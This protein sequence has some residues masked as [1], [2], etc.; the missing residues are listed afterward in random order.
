MEM[1]VQVM[2]E[3]SS[4]SSLPASEITNLNDLLQGSSSFPTITYICRIPT[5]RLG[6]GTTKEILLSNLLPPAWLGRC[7]SRYPDPAPDCLPNGYSMY[8][9]VLVCHRARGGSVAAPHPVP[10][11]WRPGPGPGRRM[12]LP[13]WPWCLLCQVSESESRSGSACELESDRPS[14][15]TAE[16]V[17]R[18]RG[19]RNVP[20]CGRLGRPPTPDLVRV[21]VPGPCS[22]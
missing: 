22:D 1:T 19:L 6:L 3:T 21:W 8:R 18:I 20:L 16:S 17:F 11:L 15:A 5:C 14:A 2:I 9:P 13:Q 7:V 12:P 4:R 10:V